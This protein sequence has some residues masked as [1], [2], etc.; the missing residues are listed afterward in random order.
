MHKMLPVSADTSCSMACL[1]RVQHSALVHTQQALHISWIEKCA[2][3]ACFRPSTIMDALDAHAHMQVPSSSHANP[4]L[5]IHS[6]PTRTISRLVSSYSFFLWHCTQHGSV[7]P[8]TK[9]EQTTHAQL[10]QWFLAASALPQ[11]SSAGT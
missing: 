5:Y 4:L 6:Q 7:S 2:A 3:Y 10:Q 11:S 8:H 1:P 9:N